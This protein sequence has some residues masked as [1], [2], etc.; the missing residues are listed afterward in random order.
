[1]RSASDTAMRNFWRLPDFLIIGAMKCGTSSLHDRLAEDPRL[2]MSQPKEP[3]FFSDDDVYARGLSWYTALFAPAGDSQ[4]CGESSTHYTK[5]PT[6]P[7][8]V[9][10]M[11]VALPAPRL[12]Y[13]MR[14]PIERIV[15]QFIHEWTR[16]DVFGDLEA[17]VRS[18]HRFLSY[19]LYATQLAPYFAAYG[20]ERV[21]LVFFERLVVYPEEELGRI[22]S[23]LGTPGAPAVRSS[24][25]PASNVSR[26]RVRASPVRERLLALPGMRRAVSFLPRSLRARARARWQMRARPTLPAPLRQELEGRID[27]DLARLDGPLGVALRC[28]SWKERVLAAPPPAPPGGAP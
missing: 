9:D 20:S 14:D 19:S 15:S 23:F 8:T 2:F 28:R 24:D 16:R 10:R 17:A 12:V 27:E 13:L 11:R 25:L 21:L 26:E 6:Y 7:H 5:L 4:L 22:L 18:H 1:M 3:N